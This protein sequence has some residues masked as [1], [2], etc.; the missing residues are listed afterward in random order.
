M[1]GP[2]EVE[3]LFADD[4]PLV[5]DSA[6]KHSSHRRSMRGE[7]EDKKIN[8]GENSDDEV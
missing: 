7:N 5:L 1:K 6:E 3:Q 8:I 2:W 4:F